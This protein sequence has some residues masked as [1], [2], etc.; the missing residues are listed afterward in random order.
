MHRAVDLHLGERRGD[1][2][3]L[4][5]DARLYRR[6][7]D[8]HTLVETSSKARTSKATGR[9]PDAEQKPETTKRDWVA[10]EKKY[11]QD[12]FKRK[13]VMERGEGVRVWDAD[14]NV[15][16][17]LVAGI[18]TNVLG[19]A[20]PAVVRAIQ[21]AG[22][23]SSSTSRTSTS[24]SGRW[25]WP[26]S[27]TTSAAACAR[28]SPTA[29]P[30]PTRARSSWRASSGGCNR[31]GAFEIISMDRSFHGRTLATTAATGQKKY[32]DT[33]RPLPDGFKQVP[34]NDLDAVKA[35]TSAKTAGRADRGGAGRGRHLPARSPSTCRGFAR[36]ATSR[37]W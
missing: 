14:G 15:Y 32:Q 25:N 16:L 34:F 24:T 20:H 31:D 36:G 11:Y 19:H 27:S 9:R 7:H 21:R 18:A 33:W 37:I 26:S 22:D 6:E 30:R 8:V 29:A 4:R 3:G 2:V 17:D 28:S 1:R 35:A 12:T 5:P 23:S 10:L 13:L